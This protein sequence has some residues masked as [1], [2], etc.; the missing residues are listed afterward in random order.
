[1]AVRDL[2]SIEVPK[3]DEQPTSIGE[4]RQKVDRG[5]AKTERDWQRKQS[6]QPA[7]ELDGDG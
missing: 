3:D 6:L 4:K 1:M 7:V 2:I 5:G